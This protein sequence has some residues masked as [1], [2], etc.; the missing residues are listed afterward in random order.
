[1]DVLIEIFYK[2]RIIELTGE[3]GTQKLG[4]AREA[5]ISEVLR[6]GVWRFRNCRDQRIREVIQVVSSFPL[7]LTVL[8]PDGVLWKCGED[9]YKEK[10][11]SSDTW[12]L[13]RG[14]KEEVRWSKLVWF[15]QGVP[16]YG[17]IPWLAI[18]GRLATGH[19]TRQWGQMQCCVYCGEPDETRDHLFFACP[20]TFTLWLNV[21]GNLFGPD[22][23]PDWE[24]TLQRMLGGTY[25]HLTYILLRLVWQTTIYFIWRE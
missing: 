7:T 22:R 3:I 5:K 1:M 18:R 2:G 24:I 23:D 11:I 10:F 15:P 20:Y 16:R 6:D 4:I 21:V 8:E 14:R 13:L 25:E 12:H 17:F 19:R 9:E